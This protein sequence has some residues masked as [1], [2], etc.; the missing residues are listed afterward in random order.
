MNKTS[1]FVIML[2]LTTIVTSAIA[3]RESIYDPSDQPILRLIFDSVMLF[4]VL[5]AAIY[6]LYV[7]GWILVRLLRFGFY[8]LKN[9]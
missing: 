2:I 7:I 9:K 6:V 3:I 1:H 8:P 5:F 4:A